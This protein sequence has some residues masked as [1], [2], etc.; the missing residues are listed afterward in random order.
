MLK[1]NAQAIRRVEMLKDIVNAGDKYGNEF[2]EEAYKEHLYAK[3]MEALRDNPEAQSTF[4][5]QLKAM[6]GRIG[7]SIGGSEHPMAAD[8]QGQIGELGNNL[9]APGMEPI[10]NR[11]VPASGGFNLSGSTW[12]GSGSLSFGA[13][14]ASNNPMNIPAIKFITQPGT[15]EERLRYLDQMED[16]LKRY[17]QNN[18][19]TANLHQVRVPQQDIQNGAD[20]KA[21]KPLQ[22]DEKYNDYRRNGQVVN[23][24]STVSDLS[25]HWFPYATDRGAGPINPPNVTVNTPAPPGT[26]RDPHDPTFLRATPP[27]KLPSVDLSQKGELDDFIKKNKPGTEFIDQLGNVQ[28]IR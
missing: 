27:P 19:Q 2:G 14:P 15:K 7:L 1:N 9:R 28:R 26:Y 25:A 18:I 16:E 6:R 5:G 22:F 10:S 21:G 11:E 3:G 12:V 23:P 17:Y 24:H 20:L 8:V 13:S 4:L